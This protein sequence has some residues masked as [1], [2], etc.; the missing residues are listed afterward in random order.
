MPERTRETIVQNGDTQPKSRVTTETTRPQASEVIAQIIYFLIGALEALLAIRVILS[1][2]GA[3]RENQFADF[4]YSLSYPFVAP[5]FGLFGY[6]VQYGVAR[7]EIET[8]VAMIVYA[9]IGWGLI[10]LSRIGR[11]PAV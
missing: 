6:Q 3:N 7:L 2:L 8:I 1:M 5:F 11:V 4:M 10:Q 9:V